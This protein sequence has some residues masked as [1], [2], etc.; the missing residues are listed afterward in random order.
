L[1]E[2]SPV[3]IH[4]QLL[5]WGLRLI[6]SSGCVQNVMLTLS[7]RLIRLCDVNQLLLFGRMQGLIWMIV[8]HGDFSWHQKLGKP[9]VCSSVRQRVEEDLALLRCVFMSG[10]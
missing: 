8:M 3:F 9:Q 5:H 4:Q 1:F 2:V 7:G 10:I 6:E